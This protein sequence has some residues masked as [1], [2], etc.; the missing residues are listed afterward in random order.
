MITTLQQMARSGEP[1][2]GIGLFFG[3]EPA[4]KLDLTNG[5]GQASFYGQIKGFFAQV[6]RNLWA[7]IDGRPIIVLYGSQALARAYDQSS[8]DYIV[9]HFSSDFGVAPYIIREQ[10]WK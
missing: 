5:T 4:I 2:P 9:E 8:F 10:S 1:F 3:T 6:P 7:L